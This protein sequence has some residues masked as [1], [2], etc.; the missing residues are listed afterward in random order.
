MKGEGQILETRKYGTK[1]PLIGAKR[2]K[3][4]RVYNIEHLSATVYYIILLKSGIMSQI[5]E[6]KWEIIS[7]GCRYTQAIM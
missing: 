6:C 5:I 7:S 2:S 4:I 3:D 1:K